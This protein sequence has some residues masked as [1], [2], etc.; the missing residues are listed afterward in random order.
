MTCHMIF[1]HGQVD[2]VTVHLQKVN[3]SVKNAARDAHTVEGKVGENDRTEK[4]Q[5][6]DC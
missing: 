1:S 3:N 6:L 4:Q 5:D 2:K